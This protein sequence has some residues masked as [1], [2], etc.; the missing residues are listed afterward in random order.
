MIDS[1]APTIKELRL[2]RYKLD[3]YTIP[4][5]KTLL[6]ACSKCKKLEILDLSEARI[7]HTIFRVDM[8]YIKKLLEKCPTLTHIYFGGNNYDTGYGPLFPHLL[9]LQHYEF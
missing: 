9:K 2:P 5:W 4:M 8:K 1:F 6:N 7:G 3:P